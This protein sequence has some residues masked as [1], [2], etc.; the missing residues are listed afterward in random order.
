MVQTLGKRIVSHRK[1]L[2]LT[3][4]QLAES[5]GVTAQAVSK[6]END[7]SCP[8]INML[9]KLSQLF[10]VTVDS[11]LGN[12]TAPVHEAE[13]VRPEQEKDNWVFHWNPGRKRDSIGL[14]LTV[15]ALGI[16]LILASYLQRDLSFW[17]LLW[18]TALF[19]YGAWGL[20]PK[21]SF[22]RIGCLLF[23]G[24]FLLDKWE[25]LPI[26]L[27]S[28]IVFPVILVLLGLSLLMDA[29]QKKPKTPFISFSKEGKQNC[30]YICEEEHFDF[31]A[32]FGN[33]TQLV[34]LARL[35]RGS[36]DTSFGNYTVDLSGVHT[37]APG[38][39]LELDCSFG[40][41]T[42]LVPSR[43]S[44]QQEVSTSFSNVELIG[45]P[46]AEPEGTI[47]LEVDVSFG[48]VIIQYI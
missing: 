1:R 34:T 48:K 40:E 33:I 6:W 12:E 38:C 2:G 26:T 11:L 37:I 10:G 9:P 7:Q 22:F 32:S 36:I 44:V 28:S 35:S 4:E 46:S 14:A 18:P 17:Q 20:F 47:V 41:T 21:L 24:Y 31:D 15:L 39:Q 45:N 42:L 29:I 19:M 16:Q 30:D 27:G 5:L 43:F 23:G 3:Q 25:L 8:D 13:V